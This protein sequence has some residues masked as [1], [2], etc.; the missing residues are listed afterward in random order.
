MDVQTILL[1]MSLPSAITGFS[2]WLLERKLMKGQ[3]AEEKK[4]EAR[5]QNEAIVIEGVMAAITLGEATA[6]ALQR[7]PDAHC[8]GDMQDAL[9]YATKVKIKHRDFIREQGID[10]LY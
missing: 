6:K 8:N 1:A 10:A 3:K 7:I 5:R 9:T 2:F 4:D